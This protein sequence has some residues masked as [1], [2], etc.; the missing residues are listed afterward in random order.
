[1]TGVSPPFNK[2]VKSHTHS[3]ARAQQAAPVSATRA[4]HP[5]FA[6]IAM[7]VGMHGSWMAVSETDRGLGAAAKVSE[8]LVC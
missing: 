7:G 2:V 8:I 5:E 3:T 4:M 1:L 6:G